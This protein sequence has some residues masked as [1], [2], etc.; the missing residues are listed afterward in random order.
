[1][2]SA[3]W[4][5]IATLY[6]AVLP[7]WVGLSAWSAPRVRAWAFT[8][9]WHRRVA[10]WF[11]AVFLISLPVE[12][13]L[14]EPAFRW[15]IFLIGAA[16]TLY[17]LGWRLRYLIR[18]PYTLPAAD[19]VRY[20]LVYLVNLVAFGLACHSYTCVTVLVNI[21]L[22]MLMVREHYARTRGVGSAA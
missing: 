15:P 21:G 17:W 5:A 22:A 1:M 9:A 16:T 10:P 20:N 11:R 18:A 7:V 14:V 13:L 8:P 4:T 19:S 12:A 6:V 3:E 2:A